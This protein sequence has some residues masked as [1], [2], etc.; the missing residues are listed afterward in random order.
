MSRI[1]FPDGFLWGAATASYQIEGAVN[2]DGR[3]ESIWDRFCHTP[4]NIMN[5]DKG[6]MACDHYHRYK[7]D[8]KTMKEMGL[9]TYR[10][11]I[12]WPRIFP[13]GKGNLNQKGLDFYNS[14]VDELLE[15][16]IE[17]AV[18][19]YHWDL[20]QKLQDLGGW[21][22]N[23]TTE[24][25]ADYAA[26]V[27]KSLG[28]RVKIWITH[29]EPWVASFLGNTTGEHAP[30]LKDF[31]TTLQVSHNMILAH[32]K[33]VN[34]FR[35]MNIKD[36]KIGITLSMSPF[37]PASDSVEDREAAVIGDGFENRWFLD[38]VFKGHYPKDIIGLCQDKLGSPVIGQGD[39]ETIASSSIDFLGIN[40]YFRILTRKSKDSTFPG[41]E[42]IKPESGWFTE[43][44]WEVYPEGIYELLT[45]VS[46][47]YGSPHIYITESGAA[48][49]DNII[50]GGIVED[51][52]RLE[53][54]KKHFAAAGRAIQDGVRLDG[55]FVWSLM[56]NFEWAF[57]YD[58]RFGLIRVDF[59]TQERLWKKSGIWYKDV[60]AKNGFEI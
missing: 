11:S 23:D 20:P 41:I 18:T 33:A 27:F 5:G 26:C 50:N 49:K 15:N 31:S 37:H 39:M 30:G 1:I 9:K 40:Y 60:I 59:E 24:Y 56:D 44:G 54:L 53:Y 17:P 29:N 21:A 19:L 7:Q 14:L 3:G 42:K 57:G 28:D 51:E 35:Q 25:F 52:D 4:G 12:A 38:P 16:G 47:D 10:F 58:R 6:D 2:E 34:V 36:G 13:E 8:I 48:F 46:R 43:M 32:A 22:R 55:Y 45:R